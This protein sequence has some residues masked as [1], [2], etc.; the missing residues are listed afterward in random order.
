MQMN[1]IPT[2]ESK[3]KFDSIQRLLDEEYVLVH[4]NATRDGVSLPPHLMGNL[5]VTLKLSRLF[6]GALAVEPTTIQ[7]EL[8]FGETYFT[9]IVP[10]EAV[11]G[12]TSVKGANIVWPE[13]TPAE[14]LQRIVAPTKGTVNGPAARSSL[15][16]IKSKAKATTHNEKVGHLKRVK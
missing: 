15:K 9:C 8:L 4:L 12:V 10:L 1:H 11:W 7:A 13:S 6:R 14:I 5:A 2:A 16:K 3:E